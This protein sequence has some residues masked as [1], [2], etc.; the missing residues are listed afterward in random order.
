MKF[1]NSHKSRWTE[2][3]GFYSHNFGKRQLNSAGV[4]QLTRQIGFNN[5]NQGAKE[6][7]LSDLQ[8]SGACPA[9]EVDSLRGRTPPCPIWTTFQRI[10]TAQTQNGNLNFKERTFCENEGTPLGTM[11]MLIASHSVAV[12]ATLVTNDRAI[13]RVK[14]HLLLEDWTISWRGLRDWGQD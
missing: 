3:G 12:G 2:P 1:V 4:G 7:P 14:Y 8:N 13:Y 6:K 5:K 9:A 11:D 10:W